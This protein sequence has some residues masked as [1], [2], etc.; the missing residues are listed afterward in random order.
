MTAKET[1]LSCQYEAELISTGQW[2]DEQARNHWMLWGCTC[3]ES[4]A[5]Q[6]EAYMEVVTR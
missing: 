2:R 4:K 6:A 1:C 5:K 3:D